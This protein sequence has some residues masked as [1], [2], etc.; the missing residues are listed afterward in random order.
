MKSPP[1]EINGFLRKGIKDLRPY[2]VPA[3]S[4]PIKLDAHENPYPLPARLRAKVEKVMADLPLNRY[5]DSGATKLRQ[6]IA[7]YTG[8]ESNWITVGNGS[9]ELIQSIMLAFG[10][11]LIYPEPT[12]D[13]Y[14][15]LAKV[16]GLSLKGIPLGDDFILDEEAIIRTAKENRA[17]LIFISS[18]N[19]PTGNIFPRERIERIIVE[20]G[21]LVVCDEAYYEFSGESFISHL[22][23]YE[24]LII[25]RTLS[26]LGLAGLRVGYMLASP[27]IIREINKV[28]LPYNLNTV[29][30]EIATLV[31]TDFEPIKRQ[32]KEIIA[33]REEV[34]QCLK[35]MPGLNP[36]P[37]RTNFIL[38]RSHLL[39]ADYIWNELVKAG[40]L[41]KNLN[42]AGALR[43]CLRVSIGT[44][45][46]NKAVTSVL[47]RII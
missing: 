24:N 32:I 46:E 17:S 1:M 31:L 40:I 30:Q 45:E 9:D 25:L 4:C 42:Q 21:S 11:A 33:Q 43:N 12:F 29:S 47:S 2:Q 28:R 39:G 19:N 35:T 6:A 14:P 26:K 10:E 20:S 13:M 8:L 3:V 41:I 7:A 23:R 22:A 16:T 27:S 37:S 38:M 34:Y 36:F 15:I 5:P 18:P 44:P